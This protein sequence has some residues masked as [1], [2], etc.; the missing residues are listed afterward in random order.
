MIN[1][2]KIIG[3]VHPDVSVSCLGDTSDYN[4]ITFNSGYVSKADLDSEYINCYK[5][6]KNHSIDQKTG[7]LFSLGF[8]Y[9]TNTFS[10]SLSAQ[11]N[12]NTLKGSEAD[13]TWPVSVSTI[14][15]G[16]YILPQTSLQAFW[17]AARDEGKVHLDGG[18]SLKQQVNAATTIAEIDAIV[19]NR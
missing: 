10:L 1:Y 5:K 14:D 19:D 12:W 3:E 8:V 13:F 16:E 9:D 4:N 17:E 7:Y 11:S 18:R 2:V 15:D 6:E